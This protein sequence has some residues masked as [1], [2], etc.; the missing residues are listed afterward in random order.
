MKSKRILCLF[1]ILL[2]ISVATSLFFINAAAAEQANTVKNPSGYSYELS[3]GSNFNYSGATATDSFSY[4]R[5]TMGTFSIT[6]PF[7]DDSTYRSTPAYGTTGGVTFNYSYDGAYQ[8]ESAEKW[9]IKSDSSTSVAGH[10]ISG[11]VGTGAVMVL[12]SSDGVTYTNVATDVNFFT[13]NKAGKTG[14]YT[15]DG[16]DILQGTYYRVIVAYQMFWENGKILFWHEEKTAECIEVYD[17][18]LCAN[19]G[20]ISIHNLAAAEDLPVVDGYDADEIAK[21]ETLLDGSTTTKGFSIDKLGTSYV[22]NIVKD[23]AQEFKNVADGTQFTENGLYRIT[24]ITKLGRQI[25]TNVYVFNGG[26]DSGYSTYFGDNLIDGRRILRFTDYPTLTDYPVYTADSKIVLQTISAN[27]PALRGT[28]TNTTT[29]DV[30]TIDGTNR[31]RQEYDLQVGTYV[32]EFYNGIDTAGTIYNYTFVFEISS[33]QSGPY[34]NKYNLDKTDRFE[35]LQTKHYEVVY[36]TAGGG[37]IFVCF[38]LDSYEEAL[39][40]AYEIEKRFIEKTDDGLY[41]KSMDNPNVKVK[42]F[43]YIEMTAA[44]NKYAKENVEINYFNSIDAF[45]FRTFDDDLLESL[46][47]LS[48][49]E[50]I[51]V[52][53]SEEERQKMISRQPF[54]NNFTFVQAHECDVVEVKA[55]CHKN[56]K[57]YDIAFGIDVSNQLTVSSKYTITEKNIYGDTVSYDVY[58]ACDNATVTEWLV[59]K[60]GVT[61]TLKISTT[62]MVN[63]TITVDA[64][65]IE[66]VKIY[67]ELDSQALVAIKAPQVYSFEIKCMLSEL[68]SIALYKKGLYEITIIDRVGNSYKINLNISGKTRHGDLSSSA[69]IYTAVYNS[70]YLN[71]KTDAEEVYL[72][73][74]AL[75]EALDVQV[76][77]SLYTATSYDAYMAVHAAAAAVYNNIDATQEELNAATRDLQTAYNALEPNS[78]LSNLKIEIIKYENADKDKYVTATYNKWTEAYLLAVSVANKAQPQESEVTAVLKNIK[79]AYDELELRG[80]KNKLV[81][82]LVRIRAVDCAIYTPNSIQALDTAFREAYAVFKNIDATQAEINAAIDNLSAKEKTL[83]EMADFDALRSALAEVETVDV[84]RYS[85]SSVS[86]LRQ[87]YESAYVVLNDKNS[88]QETVDAAVATLTSAHAALK[89]VAE[90][91]ALAAKLME[92]SNINHLIYEQAGVSALHDKYVTALGILST[93]RYSQE[94]IT[95]ICEELQTLVEALQEQQERKELFDLVTNVETLDLEEYKEKKAKIIVEKHKKA[96]DTLRSPEATVEQLRKAKEE[97]EDAIE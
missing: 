7:N 67:N 84:N 48:L 55:Y 96:I 38:S 74:T 87:A 53:P 29:G 37:Y 51:K 65:S 2:L 88:S 95:E 33:E 35:D 54:I 41:Y 49:R 57:T 39:D 58:Y 18:Y 14:F 16:N 31:Q 13:N 12:K 52:F 26:A 10:S 24:A 93:G 19:T 76:N 36:Q 69:N 22:V 5:K 44:I 71:D 91:T 97:L 75:K 78:N 83:I 30:I 80:N 85:S 46:E 4:G 32:C 9:Y 59:T 56:G 8:D 21:G 50:S 25:T 68:S 77:A 63:G 89:T 73:A 81:S 3:D 6:G 34:V 61:T 62:D 11:S 47:D 90:K 45:T 70:I 23:G 82:L 20:V 86:A 94:E 79:K 27:I 64:D 60:D 72:D 15:T 17:F 92:I 1:C 28:I 40:Y 42:Y 43:D 66:I